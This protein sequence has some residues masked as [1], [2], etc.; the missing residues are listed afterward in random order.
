MSGYNRIVTFIRYYRIVEVTVL[1]L[2]IGGIYGLFLHYLKLSA[3]T[4]L[5]PSIII[6]S[7]VGLL[8]STCKC[9]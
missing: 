2:L 6:A 1:G 8:I 4:E 9:A 7:V 3:V 5:V